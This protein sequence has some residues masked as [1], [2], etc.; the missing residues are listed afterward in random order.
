LRHNT[1]RHNTVRK[2]TAFALRKDGFPVG[3]VYL[4]GSGGEGRVPA[5][6]DRVEVYGNLFDRNWSG[7]TAFSDANRFCTSPVNTSRGACTRLVA[8]TSDC[9]QPGISTEPLF[10]DCRW[11]TQHLAVHDNTFVF[12]PSA[13]GCPNGL[14]GTMA[15]LA[16]TG[17]TPDWSPYRGS[18][19]QDAVT[20][21][22]DNVWSHNV[23]VGPWRF[24]VHDTTRRVDFNG[25][26]EGP[27]RQDAGSIS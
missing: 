5:R 17:T 21:R 18:T 8:N 12:D 4:N 6:T 13:V 22:Q 2:G 16:N 24:V 20:F 3:A 1:I 23:Y 7:I 25:W 19:V 27:Y 9:V 14:C 26:R 15:L 10:S 11:K